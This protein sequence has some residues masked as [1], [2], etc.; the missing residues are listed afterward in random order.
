MAFKLDSRVRE[1]FTTSGTG[2]ITTLGAIQGG[3]AFSSFMSTGDTTRYVASKGSQS[4]EG[5]M[6]FT[7]PNTV[8]RTTITRNS[9]ND[10]NPVDFLA[11][12]GEIF[13]DIP[14][15]WMDALNLTE[16]T[17]TC[18]ATI[19]LGAA[20]GKYIALSGTTGPVTSFGNT[21]KNKERWVTHSGETITHNGTSL[22]LVGVVNWT[23]AS[24]DRSLFRQD[25]S[26]NW[27]EIYRK[28]ASDR[29]L[30]SVDGAVSLP[31]YS[32]AADPDTGIYRIGANNIGVAVNGAK[33]LDV[34][35]TGL[36]L[37]GAL[38][39][40]AGT[41]GDGATA[42]T[43][44][45]TQPASP[46]T[47][48]NAVLWSITSAGS[49][50]QTNRGFRL[51]YEAGYTGPSITIG[52]SAVNSAAGTGSSLVA[53]AGATSPTGNIA[54]NTTASA[55]TTGLNVGLNGGASNGNVNAGVV[56]YAQ[57][58]KNAATN[59][60]VVGTAIN[61]GTSPVH[62]GGFFCLNQTTTPSVSA[63]LIAD[64]GSQTDPVFLARDN[65]ATVFTIAD[66]GAVTA[67]GTVKTL[68]TTVAGLPAAGT[69]GRRAFVTDANT[70]VIL[71][72]GLTVV[73][74]GANNVPVYDDGTN[75]KIG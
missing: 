35:T 64:N 11:G 58:A 53:A 28:Y 63:A 66:G 13:C 61:T 26:G 47:G 65:G 52:F 42:L 70:T 43:L 2:S 71:G 62:I 30:L 55:T 48:Q 5:I 27:K 31:A 46:S 29:S 14:A 10:L 49:A 7:S 37:T 75:W 68:T 4:E 19:D 34:S 39:A 38:A 54:T 36:G 1:S 20:Q 74:G 24:G 25:S 45:A 3:R 17:V 32:F 59:I 60:G 21:T 44:T 16:I 57:I 9:N 23:T 50:S 33:V 41:L 6:T 51:Q 12:P 40:V 73:G 67:T 18:A 15:D 69:A 56:G 72:L 22:A 8:A